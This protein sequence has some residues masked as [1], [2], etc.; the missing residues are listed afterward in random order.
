[1]PRAVGHLIADASAAGTARGQSESRAV[2]PVLGF[3]TSAVLKQ[4]TGEAQATW[5]TGWTGGLERT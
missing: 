1:M 2:M 5:L 3:G 4:L